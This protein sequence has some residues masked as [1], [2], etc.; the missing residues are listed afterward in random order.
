MF[1]QYIPKYANGIF[2]MVLALVE[3][4]AQLTQHHTDQKVKLPKLI[5]QYELILHV[6]IS[7]KKIKNVILAKIKFILGANLP[8]NSLILDTALRMGKLNDMKCS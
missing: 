5:R 4:Y 1:T 6:L 7:L 2:A 8:V 3:R